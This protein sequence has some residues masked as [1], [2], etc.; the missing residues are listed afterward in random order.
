MDISDLKVGNTF[1]MEGSIYTVVEIEHKQQPRL[2]AVIRGRLRNVE[3]GQV[4]EKRFGAGDKIG[5]AYLEKKDMQYLYKDDNLYYF[6]DTETYDQIV[7]DEAKVKDVIGYIKEGGVVSVHT[8]LERIVAVVPPVFVELK[9]VEC[10]P[11]VAGD[12]VKSSG[13]P[14]VM[15]TGL[16]V[17]VPLFISNG[18]IIKIDTRTGDYVERVN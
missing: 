12:S 9:I 18:E 15:E 5:N 7:V 14:A 10:D 8:A 2:A 1:E 16:E 17:K 13:K 6:M 11:A 4:I 3:T